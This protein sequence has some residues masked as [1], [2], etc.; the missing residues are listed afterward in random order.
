[1]SQFGIIGEGFTDQITIENILCGFFQASDLEDEI[2]YLLPPQN[3]PDKG[4]WWR[5]FQRIAGEE[6][7]NDV[8]N[9]EFV[10]LQIDTDVSEKQNFN[11]PKIDE[12]GNLLSVESLISK[13][14]DRLI[15]EINKEDATFYQLYKNKIIFAI[16]V[17]SLE[18]WLIALHDES[19]MTTEECFDEL[20]KI[21]FTNFPEIPHNFQVAKKYSKYNTL[22]QPF[23]IRE[24]IDAVVE[25]DTSFK[26]F[27]QQLQSISP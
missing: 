2:Q 15:V 25:K 14:I 18:C 6:F 26:H 3:E 22:S 7:K 27:I 23:L 21:K 9:N 5:V 4:A 13:V 16:S 17:H 12:N 20:R 8:L 10:I 11:V 19:K 1:M 24:H